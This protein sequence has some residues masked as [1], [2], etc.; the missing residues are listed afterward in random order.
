[1]TATRN[2]GGYS[3][4]LTQSNG[5]KKIGESTMKLDRGT[6]DYLR[7]MSFDV[8][9][10]VVYRRTRRIRAR[11]KLEAKEM[12]RDRELNVASK[13]YDKMNKIAYEVKNVSAIKAT[14]S[15][16]KAND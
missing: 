4:E 2:D 6:T 8:V 16:E 3:K 9:V 10:E 14:P 1:M 5:Q 7:A 13:R 12:A 11:N 15:G